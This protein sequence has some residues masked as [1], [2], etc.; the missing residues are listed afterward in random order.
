VRH[1]DLHL[2]SHRMTQCKT[3]SST[4]DLQQR[5]LSNGNIASK[6]RGS[7]GGRERAVKRDVHF[8]N[9]CLVLPSSTEHHEGASVVE[10]IGCRGSMGSD[11][12]I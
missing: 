11:Q 2:E 5:S 8:K 9:F 1:L 3:W 6:G 10:E 4:A 12:S 7:G